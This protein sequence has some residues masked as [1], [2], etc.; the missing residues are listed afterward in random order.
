MLC[1]L[2]PCLLPVPAVA[3]AGDSSE[4]GSV[5]LAHGSDPARPFRGERR[6]NP[7]NEIDKAPSS[8]CS[9]QELGL[10]QAGLR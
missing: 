7:G 9:A 2:L 6:L 1:C 5:V 3:Q 8:L 10:L 4:P